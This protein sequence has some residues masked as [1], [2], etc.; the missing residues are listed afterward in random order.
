M[1]TGTSGT[2]A[3]I[4]G[5]AYTASGLRML[6]V[7]DVQNVT[8]DSLGL[9]WA[10]CWIV[11][12]IAL[13]EMRVAGTSRFARAV[14]IVLIAGFAIASMWAAYRLI[15]A[16]AADASILAIAPIFVI[17]GMLGTG[18]LALRTGVLVTW[19]RFLPLFIAL[20]YISTISYTIATGA[21][22]LG[23]AFTMAGIA[24]MLLGY[25]IRSASPHSAM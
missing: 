5:A 7:G 13:L 11:G 18:V 6:A 8:S 9:I 20:V 25:A 4:G 19:R 22:T 23:V 12:G 24:Y 15:D 14:S 10:L 1:T 16:P 2:I 17:L 21:E 3:M